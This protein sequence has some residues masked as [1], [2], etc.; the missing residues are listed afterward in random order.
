MRI[1]FILPPDGSVGGL[2]VIS[3]YAKR[4]AQRGHDV[5]A[6]H[7]LHPRIMLREMFRSVRHGRGI[8]KSLNGGPSYFDRMELPLTKGSF[9]RTAL[10][11]AA[12]ATARGYTGEDATDKFE[13]TLRQV[14]EAGR[15]AELQGVGEM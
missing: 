8:P 12:P 6:I 11:P 2:R 5:S 13:T 4:L 7:P 10:D 9:R 14:A 15:V 1:N 3:V